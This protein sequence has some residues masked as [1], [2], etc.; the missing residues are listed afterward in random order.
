[1][2]FLCYS[3]TVIYRGS[4]KVGKGQGTEEALFTV[5]RHAIHLK[6]LS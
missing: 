6:E 2:I 3:V 1:L 5:A 4:R